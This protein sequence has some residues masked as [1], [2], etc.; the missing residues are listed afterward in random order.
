MSEKSFMRENQEITVSRAEYVQSLERGLAVIKAFGDGRHR[1]TIADVAG[2]V[3]ISRGAARR[4]LL[5]LHELGYVENHDRYYTLRPNVLELGYTVLSAQPWWPNGQEIAQWLATEFQSPCAIG[6]LDNTSVV[7]VCYA[8]AQKS[9]AFNRAVGTRLPAYATAI[10]RVL[11]AGLT[12][13]DVTAC[14]QDSGIQALTP[15]TLTSEKAILTAVRKTR[16][17]GYAYV[18]Q[19]LEVGLASFGVPIFS[20]S[21]EIVAAMSISFRPDAIQRGDLERVFS[22]PLRRAASE[23]T[24]ILP[25]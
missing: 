2:A 7:Y 20:R 8:T 17:T 12:D 25:N 23:I 6:V 10:G 5:T 18:D 21:K 9:A 11:L 3:G 4:F 19:E 13:D 14:L 15:L 22:E 16:I 24:D 1:M